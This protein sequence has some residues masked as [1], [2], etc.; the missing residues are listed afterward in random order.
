MP[1]PL[2]AV[3]AIPGLLKAGGSLF[4]GGAR[5]REQDAARQEQRQRSAA[6]EGH[7]FTQGSNPFANVTNTAAGLTNTFQNQRV[8]TQ[9]AEFQSEQ[10]SQNIAN[11][12]DAVRQGGGGAAAASALAGRAAQAQQG[13]AANL[14]Q[15]EANISRQTALQGAR[16]QEQKAQGEARRQQLYGQGAQY[17]QQLRFQQ[18]QL[19]RDRLGTLLGRADQ[20]LGAANKARQQATQQL[21]SGLGSAV[22]GF[23]AAG[24]FSGAGELNAS[25]IAGGQTNAE[26]I[27]NAQA[28]GFGTPTSGQIDLAR[29]LTTGQ[30]GNIN[31]L[32]GF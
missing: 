27:A 12:A 8:A 24:G 21:F 26:F 30:P 10:T 2:A 15:Q 1:L 32:Q 18:Q 13:I 29:S 6:Y 5:R 9:A 4:G 28:G 7:Q 19:D 23:A 14:Q 3:A 22:G 25:G 17:V 16:I 31:L 20:R 11:I